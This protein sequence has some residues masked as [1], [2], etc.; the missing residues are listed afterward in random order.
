MLIVVV[1]VA[2]AVAIAAVVVAVVVA[3]AVAVAVN[4]FFFLQVLLPFLY[5]HRSEGTY[6]RKFCQDTSSY[7]LQAGT[8]MLYVLYYADA[9]FG[10]LLASYFFYRF[11]FLS[12][13]ITGVKGLIN[14]DN[15]DIKFFTIIECQ[16]TN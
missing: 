11:C 4:F 1:V 2:V 12:F 9:I 16:S 6:L 13:T 8:S 5:N 10:F 7:P 14:V 15:V 3:V